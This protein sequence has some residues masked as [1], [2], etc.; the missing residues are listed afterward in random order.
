MEMGSIDHTEA[1][2]HS[3]DQ[4]SQA[5]SVA[6]LKSLRGISIFIPITVYVFGGSTMPLFLVTVFAKYEKANLTKAEQA[7]A[8]ALSNELLATYELAVRGKT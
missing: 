7:A 2:G 5:Q 1:P 8:V 3:R 6:W 4:S